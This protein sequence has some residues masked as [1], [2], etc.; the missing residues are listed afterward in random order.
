MHEWVQ[1]GCRTAGIGCLDCKQPVIDAVQAELKPIQ[2]RA[3]DFEEDRGRVRIILQEGAEAA[4]E[5][6]QETMEDALSAIGFTH[7]D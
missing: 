7:H 5:V 4:R 2:E 1:E 6:A 3:R